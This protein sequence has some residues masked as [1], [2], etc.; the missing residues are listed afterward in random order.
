[1]GELYDLASD[2]HEM[3]NLWDDPA[4]AADK[5]VFAGTPCPKNDGTVGTQPAPDPCGLDAVV[6]RMEDQKR[7]YA[8]LGHNPGPPETTRPLPDY[9]QS[10]A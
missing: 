9:A 6:A 2:P 10:R 1:M 7:V 5:L 3:H 4:H 8:F